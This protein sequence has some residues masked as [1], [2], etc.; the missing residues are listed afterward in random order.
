MSFCLGMCVH[1]KNNK[2]EFDV[3]RSPKSHFGK[4]KSQESLWNM[5]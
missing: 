2:S 5:K 1:F 3:Q 4:L